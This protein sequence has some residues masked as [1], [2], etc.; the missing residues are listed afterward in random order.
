MSGTVLFRADAFS[1]KLNK[2]LLH[3]V[4]N[5]DLPAIG[6][7][8][9]L[10]ASPK[11]TLP[12][13]GHRSLLHIAALKGFADVA[14][15]LVK[16]GADVNARDAEDVTPLHCASWNN[17]IHTV[18][19]LTRIGADVDAQDIDDETPMHNAAE[20]GNVPVLEI[21]MENGADISLQNARGMTPDDVARQRGNHLA[22]KVVENA[23]LYMY[24]Y[25]SRPGLVTA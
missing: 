18:D 12:D 5:N 21:L 9:R 25:W 10:G 1:G 7:L 14:D 15:E 20:V 22:A 4:E 3:A 2:Q 19:K 6:Q 11:H 24:R 16:R 23:S 8:V 17:H 13:N